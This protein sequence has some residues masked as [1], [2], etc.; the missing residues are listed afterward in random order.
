MHTSTTT[1]TTTGTADVADPDSDDDEVE[2]AEEAWLPGKAFTCTKPFTGTVDDDAGRENA[3][4][5]RAAVGAFAPP[6]TLACRSSGC[7]LLAED[8]R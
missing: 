3:V 6:C 1:P 5:V 4:D 2:N 7:T 8:D